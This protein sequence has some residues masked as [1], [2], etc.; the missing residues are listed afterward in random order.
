MT[1]GAFALHGG[2][3]FL[4]GDERF[5]ADWLERARRGRTIAGA[6]G[7]LRVA[8]VPTAAARQRP[9]LA[10][11][12]GRDAIERVAAHMGVV[13]MVDIIPIVDAASA[14]DPAL[15]ARL[16]AADAV[17]LPGGDPDLLPAILADTPAL[18]AMVEALD[19]GAIIAGASAGAMALAAW[20][21][22]PGGIVPGLGLLPEPALA[23]VPHADARSWAGAAERFGR[24]LPR[25]VGLLGLGERTAVIVP[26]D[27][28][29]PWTVVGEGEVRLQGAAMSPGDPPVI[30][31]HGDVLDASPA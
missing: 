15:A 4:P 31:R 20:T 26:R 29:G 11:R 23:V 22:T 14:A 24:G 3:E 18:T 19:R 5:L 17:H 12:H 25:G 21:W 2:G 1:G 13:A 16:A 27:G 30:R 28:S 6:G 10:A 8:I 7:R 9:D